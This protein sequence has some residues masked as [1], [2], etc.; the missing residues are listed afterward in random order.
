MFRFNYILG[1]VQGLGRRLGSVLG[2]NCPKPL[3][4]GIYPGIQKPTGRE[5]QAIMQF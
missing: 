1:L 3:S 2:F 5:V 4:I